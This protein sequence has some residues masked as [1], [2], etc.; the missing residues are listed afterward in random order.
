MPVAIEKE[1]TASKPGVL[2]TNHC[3]CLSSE[4]GSGEKGKPRLN[5][6]S[7]LKWLS[8]IQLEN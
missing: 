2:F 5:I 8:E 1:R 4:N 3:L 6:T 7:F